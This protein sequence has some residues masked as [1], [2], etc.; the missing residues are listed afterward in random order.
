[1]TA[2]QFTF[3][4]TLP[5]PPLLVSLDS[6]SPVASPAGWLAEGTTET[7]GNNVNAY[8]DLS[9]PDGFSGGDFRASITSPNVFDYVANVT[10]PPD[11]PEYRRASIVQVNI[12]LHF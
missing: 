7:V 10:G 4:S 5:T 6:Y 3:F 2:T 9:E 8:V 11:T 1:M 12:S